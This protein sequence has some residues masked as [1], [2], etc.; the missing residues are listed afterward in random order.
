MEP[1]RSG[2]P[3]TATAWLEADA[4]VLEGDD[5]TVHAEL[6]DVDEV[7]IVV[8][9]QDDRHDALIHLSRVQAIAL[10]G[11]IAWAATANQSEL[12]HGHGAGGWAT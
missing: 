10:A 8:A 6:S 11:Q 3:I 7:A 12:P 1:I 2:E 9:S 4:P 5:V